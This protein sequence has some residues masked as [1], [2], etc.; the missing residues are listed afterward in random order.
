MRG[1]AKQLVFQIPAHDHDLTLRNV[2]AASQ[3]RPWQAHI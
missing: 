1:M 2:E 3:M